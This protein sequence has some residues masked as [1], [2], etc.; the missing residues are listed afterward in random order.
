MVERRQKAKQ[1]RC[2]VPLLQSIHTSRATAGQSQA[3]F[4]SGPCCLPSFL[5]IQRV[6]FWGPCGVTGGKKLNIAGGYKAN[7]CLCVTIYNVLVLFA[8][9]SV[10]VCLFS[11]CASFFFFFFLSF[12]VSAIL[13]KHKLYMY[14]CIRLLFI[15]RTRCTDLFCYCVDFC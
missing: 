9:L 4:R 7:A 13:C 12:F 14:I 11:V 15:L 3:Y 2:A 5:I 10:S 1:V 6:S 8:C